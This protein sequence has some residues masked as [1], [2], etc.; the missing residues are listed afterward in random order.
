MRIEESR[1][2]G[3]FQLSVI[4]TSYLSVIFTS[5][6]LYSLRLAFQRMP[7]IEAPRRSITYRH[8]D[9]CGCMFMCIL[10][11]GTMEQSLSGGTLVHRSDINNVADN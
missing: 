11:R 5:Y 3:Y 7:P 6:P 8:V 2:K 10:P 9:C 4:F 1:F